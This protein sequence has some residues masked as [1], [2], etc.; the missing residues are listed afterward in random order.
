MV[1]SHQWVVYS[2]CTPAQKAIS[3]I[4]KEA[5]N[6]Y[7]GEDGT[8]YDTYY[9]YLRQLYHKKVLKLVEYCKDVGLNPMMPEGAFYILCDI[10]QIAIPEIFLNETDSY[11]GKVTKDFAFCNFLTI[12]IGVSAI[13]ASTFYLE[14]NKSKA[15]NLIRLCACKLDTTID[16]AGK[17]LQKLKQ[18]HL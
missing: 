18:Y 4:I 14:E 16:E 13:P 5:N 2:V 3:K 8:K 12:E 11:G 10:S 1:A 6:P 9:D 15:S 17:R 7:T